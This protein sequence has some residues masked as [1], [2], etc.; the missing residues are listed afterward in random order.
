MF[1]HEILSNTDVSIELYYEKGRGLIQSSGKVL[2]VDETEINI[3]L[4]KRFKVYPELGLKEIFLN[5]ILDGDFIRWN[6]KLKNLE[7]TDTNT[8]ISLHS[9]SKGTSINKRDAFR[10]LYEDEINYYLDNIEYQGKLKDISAIGLS[11]KSNVLHKL[12]SLLVFN[13]NTKELNVI[14]KIVRVEETG[15]SDFQYSYGVSII[16]KDISCFVF[17]KQA[18]LIRKGRYI[19]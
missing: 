7:Y 16:D 17:R 4:T 15:K 9:D 13:S 6:C 10:L 19:R 18:E 8:I 1:I 5:T 11:F 2:N 14:G 12:G 3:K